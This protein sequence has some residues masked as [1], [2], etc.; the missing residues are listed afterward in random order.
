MTT[1]TQG[2][3]EQ[4]VDGTY[5][6]TV[7]RPDALREKLIPLNTE[8]ADVLAK[9]LGVTP[10]RASLLRWRT[11]GYPIDRDGP[12]VRLPCVTHLKRVKTSVEA[13]RRWLLAV[14]ALGAE[15]N[16]VGSVAAWHERKESQRGG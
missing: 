13:L 3:T 12:R 2:Y 6:Y 16:E 7:D 10:S 11:D 15:I 5:I 1:D 8:G 9:R 4:Y 14:Q